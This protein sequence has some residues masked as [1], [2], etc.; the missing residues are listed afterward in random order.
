MIYTSKGLL[1]TFIEETEGTINE[2]VVDFDE[3]LDAIINESCGD[4]TIGQW[5]FLKEDSID[6]EVRFK[7]L[8]EV[9]NEIETDLLETDLF[10]EGLTF[11]DDEEAELLDETVIEC[12]EEAAGTT[13][14]RIVKIAKKKPL[15][16]AKV[17]GKRLTH[18]VGKL[19]TAA[20]EKL[21]DAGKYALEKSK[22]YK[23]QAAEFLKNGKKEAA[24]KAGELASKFAQKAKDLKDKLMI[25]I[26]KFQFNR[27]QKK[28]EKVMK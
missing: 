18:N 22:N 26:K 28:F 19:G 12:L 9:L 2:D 3:C 15:T 17:A 5:A 27:Q 21:K 4:I 7:I 8:D 10:L 20:I 11:E 6:Y 14:K 24:K 16:A 25:A 13:L 1:D 23:T